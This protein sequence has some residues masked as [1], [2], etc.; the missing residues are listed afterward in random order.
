MAKFHRFLFAVAIL[1]LV[2]C[3]WVHG[4]MY[5][6]MKAAHQESARDFIIRNGGNVDAWDHRFD[7]PIK[8]DG[9]VVLQDDGCPCSPGKCK[10]GRVCRCHMNDADGTPPCGTGNPTGS[11]R[12]DQ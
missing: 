9:M 2:V 3:A 1:G 8:A 6:Q 4:G 5:W 12:C 7:G 11:C 10:C